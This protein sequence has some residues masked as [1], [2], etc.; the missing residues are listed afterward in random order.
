[1]AIGKTN[2][3]ATVT[4][5]K[6]DFGEVALNAQKF[7]QDADE[8][9]LA[10][11]VATK[12][13]EKEIKPL[14]VKAQTTGHFGFD[15]FKSEE[16]ASLKTQHYYKM[17]AGDIEGANTI[18]QQAN[19]LVSQLGKLEESFVS[20]DEALKGKKISNVSFSFAEGMNSILNGNYDTKEIDGNT[21]L[22]P[23]KTRSDG[24]LELDE[25]GNKIPVEVTNSHGESKPYIS[26]TD[27]S[28]WQA[29]TIPSQSLV[30]ENGKGLVQNLA[31]SVG[32]YQKRNESGDVT[33]T[34]LYLDDKDYETLN[35]SSLEI[36]ISDRDTMADVANQL[37]PND[38][39]F[40]R[41]KKEY[42]KQEYEDV[43]NALVERVKQ[44]YKLSDSRTVDEPKTFVAKNTESKI[45]FLN[46]EQIQTEIKIAENGRMVKKNVKSWV[47][48]MSSSDRLAAALGVT[49]EGELTFTYRQKGSD[50]TGVN[51]GPASS[52][53][54]EGSLGGATSIL[55]GKDASSFIQQLIGVKY[56]DADGKSKTISGPIDV[57]N[58]VYNKAVQ[59]NADEAF[60][61]SIRR[62]VYSQLGL[63]YNTDDK[64]F[65]EKKFNE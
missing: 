21:V 51:T 9:R 20:F 30:G 19:M 4:A 45:P 22:I 40:I 29:M 37:F 35:K 2:A 23:Y 50:S 25:N 34:K 26:L 36:L 24:K 10:K 58:Y 46:P 62:N 44:V 61:T 48:S 41:P 27:I 57:A 15:K 53:Y 11:V 31:S 60:K 32:V 13:K 42:T 17:S 49:S 7:Q 55:E 54:G 6:V 64:T 28:N 39:R 56:L 18:E 12:T 8:K 14:D 38:E 1:M 63:I 16:L 52:K 33:T 65:R 5:P 59:G 47:V 3:F 43:K